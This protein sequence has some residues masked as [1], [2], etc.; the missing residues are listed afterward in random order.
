MPRQGHRETDMR[1]PA[2]DEWFATYDNP[3][4]EVLLYMREAILDSDARIEE[5][6]KW[7]SPT[8]SYKGNIASFMPRSKKHAS[9][10]F[11]TGATIP[12]EF[13]H[14]QGTGDVARYFN[15]ADLE[16]A[17]QLEPELLSIFRAWCDMKDAA[18]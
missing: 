9:L 14:L 18:A 1:N 8:F 13:P 17:R 6:I 3:Q 7:K 15:V 4:K 12:G 2:V 10:M 11:H 16:E 5:S